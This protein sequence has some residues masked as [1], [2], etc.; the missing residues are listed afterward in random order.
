MEKSIT[1]QNTFLKVLLPTLFN[2][3]TLT[4]SFQHRFSSQIFQYHHYLVQNI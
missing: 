4:Y 1:S 2:T 3:C